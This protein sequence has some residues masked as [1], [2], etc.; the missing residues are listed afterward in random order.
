LFN[1]DTLSTLLYALATGYPDRAKN[2]VY[3]SEELD[4]PERERLRPIVE[5][6]TAGAVA[7]VRRLG[8]A[9]RELGASRELSNECYRLAFYLGQDSVALS[10]NALFAYF[11]A[12]R[13]GRLLDKWIHYF[14]IYE[15]H[16]APYRD[17]GVRLLE[18]GVYQGG[19]LD[20]WTRYLGE[21][22][23]VIGIDIDEA[24]LRLADPGRTVIIGDQADPDFLRSVDEQHGPFDVV[25]DDGGHTMEQQIASI[26]TLFPTLTDGGIYIVEDSHTSYWEEFGGGERREGTFIEWAKR[27]IDDLHRY[28]LPGTVDPVWTAHVDAIHCYDSV[29]VFDKKARTPPFSE[30]AGTSDFVFHQR[31]ASVLVGEMLATRDAAIGQRE[32][33]EARLGRERLE[34][35]GLEARLGEIEADRRRVDLELTATRNDLSE[36]WEQIRAMRHTISWRITK[37]LRAVRRLVRRR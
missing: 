29:V 25:V 37:P 28:H 14:P 20:M 12:Y 3:V 24:A 9:L 31:P 17:R 8:D 16:L 33:L 19:S 21:A 1:G 26:E 36:S 7:Q 13:S 18:I 6:E 5:D 11:V 34:R 4:E 15:K 2:I 10:E 27:R 32:D 35:Q 22:A 30:Q 23:T